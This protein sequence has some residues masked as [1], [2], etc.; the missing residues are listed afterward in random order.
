MKKVILTFIAIFLCILTGLADEYSPKDIVPLIL[1]QCRGPE[2]PTP[3][4]E[5]ADYAR[6]N[7]LSNA[8]VSKILVAFIEDG[9][10]CGEDRMR[11]QLRDASLWA[12]VRFGGKHESEYVRD[13]MRTTSD[14]GL[15]Q[16]SVRVGMRLC[17]ENWEEWVREVA[18][19]N[20]FG[21]L[22]RFDAYE[23]A[24]RI[25]Q[26]KDEKTRQRV[27]QVLSEFIEREKSPG[28]RT[29]LQKWAAEL[30]NTEKSAD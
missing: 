29:D 8:E 18:A 17:P 3:D 25:G 11:R 1:L 23:E 28:N 14:E 26:S 21:S 24:F 15:C 9:L 4:A 19:D 2:S 13:I 7:G 16:I 5:L 27:E 30:K 20:R 12:L 10:Q 6:V 22:T